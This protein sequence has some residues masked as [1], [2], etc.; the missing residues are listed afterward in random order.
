MSQPSNSA[1]RGSAISSAAAASP[2]AATGDYVVNLCA[3]TTP[4][5]L[6][7]PSAPELARYTFFV[8]R[9]REEG[10][11]RFR[12]H[13]GY[14]ATRDEAER[15]L[16]LVRDLYPAAWVGETPGR[17]LAAGR[18][19][20]AASAS[21][22]AAADLPQVRSTTPPQAARPAAAPAVAAPVAAAPRRP[23]TRPS[24]PPASNV[25]EVIA[26]LEPELG[27]ADSGTVQMLPQQQS[28][29]VAGALA[30][31]TAAAARLAAARRAAASPRTAPAPAPAA[32]AKVPAVQSTAPGADMTDSQVLRVLEGPGTAQGAR[33][34]AMLSP[35]DTQTWRDIKA[36]IKREAVVHFAVQLN[37][38]VTPIDLSRVP[39]LAIFNAYT[40]YK[41]EGNREGRKWYGL[42]LGFFSDAVSA[43]QV[44]H[45]VRSEFA[46]VAVVPVSV[47]EREQ[48]TQIG[49][50]ALPSA[51]PAPRTTDHADADEFKLIDD[52]QPP[53]AAAASAV[54]SAASPPGPSAA[55]PAAKTR[56]VA[57]SPAARAPA[58]KVRR[59]NR[60]RGGGPQ[61]L[62]ETLEIL[63]ASQLSIDTG[64]GE[65]V[66]IDGR[67]RAVDPPSSA[68]T[69]LLD[70][71]SD[72]LRK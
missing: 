5:A 13:M 48:A 33:D 37:W 69:R 1:V 36:Q 26:A 60:P 18:S 20:T 54:A 3:S 51:A 35:Q 62:E 28:P 58:V 53:V 70:R 15:M 31:A 46:Q 71:L 21:S 11:E 65:R 38:S 24:V 25:R 30:A 63:G 57:A 61:S 4:M 2:A 8:S 34:I 68:F 14:F 32:P 39:S 56:P 6:A 17:K 22:A 40:L 19:S 44:A 27:P 45:Y 64:R 7:K 52:D 72:K 49:A 67:P 66:V 29:K 43:K 10:R 42:R 12:L 50:I 59:P 16:A 55:A 47:N 41:I 9:R 23:V